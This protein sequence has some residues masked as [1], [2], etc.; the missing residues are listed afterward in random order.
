AKTIC[1]SIRPWSWRSQAGE[2]AD[3]LAARFPKGNVKLPQFSM[4]N[5]YLP[6][7]VVPAAGAAPQAPMYPPPLSLNP[8][9]ATT[10]SQ[11]VEL[12][13]Q[14][15]NPQDLAALGQLLTGGA[16]AA[17]DAIVNTLEIVHYGDPPTGVMEVLPGMLVIT[18]SQGAHREIAEL[19]EELASTSP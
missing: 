11:S 13:P 2:I 8:A 15:I 9:S 6:D 5:S 18:Q 7:G 14:E 4:A 16:I 10:S 17:V 12:K 19:L 1:H 3:R